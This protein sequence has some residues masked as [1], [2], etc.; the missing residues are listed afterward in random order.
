MRIPRNCLL[1]GPSRHR[2]RHS[3]SP[4][5][6]DTCTL[7]AD[8]SATARWSS[9]EPSR[10]EHGPSFTDVVADEKQLTLDIR[11]STDARLEAIRGRQ[12]VG[13]A[14]GDHEFRKDLQRLNKAGLSVH[15]VVHAKHEFVSRDR[16]SLKQPSRRSG[17]G[18]RTGSQ[19]CR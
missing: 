1:R 10:G 15:R 2:A 12:D 18:N 6:L 13:A 7:V 9:G 16:R 3:P 14:V 5:D 8:V 17:R 4:P 19:P 11:V